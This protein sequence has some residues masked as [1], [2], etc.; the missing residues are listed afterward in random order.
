MKEIKGILPFTLRVSDKKLCYDDNLRSLM[1]IARKN[2]SKII[3]S[4]SAIEK[5]ISLIISNY[6][7]EADRAKGINF[8]NKVLN[9]DWCSFSAK[10][11]LLTEIINEKE[12]IEGKDKSNLDNLLSKVLKY[13][14]AFAH[15]DLQTDGDKYFIVYYA[16][17]QIDKELNDEY[18]TTIEND[19]Y[20]AM[21]LIQNIQIISGAIKK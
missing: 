3:E 10:R 13:R 7:F 17:K 14:N 11:K 12:Y 2:K 16:G 4:A 9:T 5:G 19:I 15:G 20:E 6:F 21:E 8:E 18:W 1:A